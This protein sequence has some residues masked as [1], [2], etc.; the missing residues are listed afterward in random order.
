MEKGIAIDYFKRQEEN[1][2]INV[3][4]RLQK[5]PHSGPGGSIPTAAVTSK[6]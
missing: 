3:H 4:S 6:G 1:L 5:S 2:L